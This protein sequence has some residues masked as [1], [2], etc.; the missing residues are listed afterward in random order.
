MNYFLN[1]LF[2]FGAMCVPQSCASIWHSRNHQFSY[3][4]WK[5]ALPEVDGWCSHW[6]L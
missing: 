2:Q 1:L 4:W 5:P 6:Y 3:W